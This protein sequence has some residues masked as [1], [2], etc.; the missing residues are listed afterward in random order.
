[1]RRELKRFKQWWIPFLS[2]LIFLLISLQ[3]LIIQPTN[4]IDFSFTL[5]LAFFFIGT[6][7][8]YYVIRNYKY[9]KRKDWFLV[10][11][12]VE[13]AVIFIPLITYDYSEYLQIYAGFILIFRA[14]IGIGVS[15]SFYYSNLKSW[16]F[17]LL[18]GT[19][20]F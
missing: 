3:I 4:Y 5:I 8:L 16:L 17:L 19:L 10:N 7:R 14:I 9:V 15:I 11:G 2:G 20:G 18:V 12:I 6:L 1:M 13:V